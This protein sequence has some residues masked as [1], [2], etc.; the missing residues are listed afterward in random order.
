MV[1]DSKQP[2]P[3]NV[4]YEYQKNNK[5]MHEYHIATHPKFEIILS[6]MSIW[7]ESTAK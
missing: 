2:I 4:Y 5:L 3:K 6:K 7:S 1:N